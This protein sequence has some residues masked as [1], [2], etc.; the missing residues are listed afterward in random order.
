MATKTCK[1]CLEEKNLKAFCTKKSSAD[2]LSGKCRD[3]AISYARQ[4]RKDSPEKTRATYKK[5]YKRI[6]ESALR[7]KYD[8]S[9][10]DYESMLKD[11][12]GKCGICGTMTPSN[13]KAVKHMYIDHCHTT[14]QVR[15]L[16]CSKCNSSIG[17]L[18][19]DPALVRRAV[20]WLEE[21]KFTPK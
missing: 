14:G 7:R 17:L 16:L 2:G 10:E 11:Q 4:Y 21:A 13:R 5:R 18:N 8:I 1:N 20:T 9:L 15:G 12:D 6:R 3:C 19:D